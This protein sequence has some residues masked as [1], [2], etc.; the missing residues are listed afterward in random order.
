MGT[1]QAYAGYGQVRLI[2]PYEIH[3]LTDLRIEQNLNEHG[4][5]LVR[6]IIPD[7]KQDTYI[8]LPVSHQTIAV[9]EVD[10]Q[11]EPGRVL[12]QGLVQEVSISA[13]QGVYYLEL[14][15]VTYSMLMDLEPRSRSFSGEE[16]T[17]RDIVDTVLGAY[18]GADK[19]DNILNN[20]RPVG[21]VLQYK[22]TDWAFIRR[23]ASQFG[24]AVFPEITAVSP[25]LFLGIPEGRYWELAL[26]PYVLH[27][28]LAWEEEIRKQTIHQEGEIDEQI[29]TVE[30]E[31]LYKLGDKIQFLEKELTVVGFTGQ[32]KAGRLVYEY[33]FTP[34]EKNL[35][36]PLYNSPLIG[37]SLDGTVVEIKGSKI[38]VHLT[39]DG[40]REVRHWLAY[41][42]PYTAEG[43][44]GGWYCMPESGDAVRVYFPSVRE[45]SAIVTS[46]FRKAPL[47]NR[48]SDPATK[49]WA[50][51]F[52]K[53][54]RF[55][56]SDIT[57]SARQERVFLK[58]DDKSGLTFQSEHDLILKSHAD[59]AASVS[60]L[61]VNAGEGIYV[62]CKSSS[63]ILDGE[64]DIKAG[65]LQVEGL[66]KSPV[67]IEDLPPVPE[68]P[69]VDEVASE[70]GNTDKASGPVGIL[71]VAQLGLQVAG[72][73]PM[74]GPAAVGAGAG[75]GVAQINSI[76]MSV[77]SS[78]PFV[79]GAIRAANLGRSLAA[80]HN[81]F[82]EQIDA[83][84]RL[85]FELA[86]AGLMG[87]MFMAA[88]GVKSDMTAEEFVE[89]L[90]R[91]MESKAYFP[92]SYADTNR[93]VIEIK[94]SLGWSDE[95]TEDVVKSIMERKSTD[96]IIKEM[97]EKYGVNVLHGYA[98][99]VTSYHAEDAGMTFGELFA[100]DAYK[101][102]EIP[103]IGNNSGK[104][105]GLRPSVPKIPEDVDP[106][107]IRPYNQD[108]VDPPGIDMRKRVLE[109]LR[110]SKATRDARNKSGYK[111]YLA[112]E[113]EILKEIE[114]RRLAGGTW[115]AGKVI[116][117]T[118]ELETHLKYREYFD[119][120]GK[121]HPN[122]KGIVGAHNS[123]EFYR[124][125]IKVVSENKVYDLNGNE[126][127]G[128]KQVVYSMPELDPKTRQPTGNYNQ[129][130]NKK[131][132]Y[133]PNV[134]SDKEYVDRGIEA[135]NNALKK[136]PTGVL[137]RVWMGVDSKGVEWVGHCENGEITSFFPTT[138]TP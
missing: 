6:G 127:I 100:T 10:D 31:Q 48:A 54:M 71:G 11:G 12:F 87:K 49:V 105:L 112:R 24:A 53:E 119:K 72:M 82:Q 25:K 80:S 7:N 77:A 36:K 120:N 94:K 106:P 60:S 56:R 64:T 101:S 99:I 2:S 28:D 84:Q 67:Y 58:I 104:G 65:S 68:V 43:H 96:D 124:N 125:N 75:L 131:T 107:K 103:Y 129:S 98:N 1:G 76:A 89:R 37:S 59:I 39:I 32:F 78:L 26:Q 122:K 113:K 66:K 134:I 90:K 62:H 115:Q 27:R 97:K 22:E 63:M 14:S 19:L 114:K 45:E 79:G 29:Y 137:P 132:I 111:D 116:T 92:E 61:R 44:G 3:T 73:F 69:F 16:G 109:S 41:E 57:L 118:P 133:D 126:V 102:S 18:D 85:G 21:M 9:Q 88:R 95:L 46:S 81:P 13:I 20:Q 8:Q 136:E 121:E 34:S 35:Q 30:T 91:E 123:E 108:I 40:E 15:A 110:I 23:I 130:T 138:P 70:A 17:Y 55:Q 83:M 4:Q 50:T 33:Q 52:G 47:P 74:V 51:P 38:Q 135:A 5:L 86:G 42:T 128:V 117:A 93:I